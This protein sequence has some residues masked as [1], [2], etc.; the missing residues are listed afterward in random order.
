MYM[1]FFVSK[2]QQNIQ[3]ILCNGQHMA[4]NLLSKIFNMYIWCDKNSNAAS[5]F[6][7]IAFRLIDSRF[8]PAFILRQVDLAGII[9]FQ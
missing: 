5:L 9:E 7:N 1:Y 3:L 4:V 8:K 2:G 6:L